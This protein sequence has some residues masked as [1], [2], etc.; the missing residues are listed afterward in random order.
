MFA[1]MNSTLP[2]SELALKLLRSI[3][4][5]LEDCAR[6]RIWGLFDLEGHAIGSSR[7]AVVQRFLDRLVSSGPAVQLSWEEL[8]QLTGTIEYVEDLTLVVGSRSSFPPYP[9]DGL[10]RSDGF[11]ESADAVIQIWDGNNV[12]GATTDRSMLLPLASAFAEG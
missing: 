1:T 5:R 12:V 3:L 11:Y 2:D 10:L 6:R 8:L 4:N 7:G 9:A